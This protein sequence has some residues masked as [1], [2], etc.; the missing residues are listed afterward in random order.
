[1]AVALN[2]DV[3]DEDGEVLVRHVF[4]GATEEE[5][6]EKRDAHMAQCVMFRKADAESRTGEFTEEIDEDEIPT[7]DDYDEDEESEEED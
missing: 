4:F 1:M 5:A 3:W 6:E 2:V 7:E